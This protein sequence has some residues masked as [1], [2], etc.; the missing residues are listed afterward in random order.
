MSERSAGWLSD[1]ELENVAP[2]DRAAFR[3]RVPALIVSDGGCNLAPQTEAQGRVEG[4]I[5]EYNEKYA[6]YQGVDRRTFLKSA[7][8]FAAAFLGINKVFGPVFGVSEAEAAEDKVLVSTEW[9]ADNL[10]A[11]DQRILDCSWYLPAL[12]R[13]ARADYRAKHLPGAVFFDIDEIADRT[14]LGAHM[15]PSAE[16]F[17]EKVGKLGIDNQTRVVVYDTNYVSARVWW[18][19]RVFGHDN[20]VVLNGKLTKWLAEGRPVESGEVSVAPRTFVA[21]KRPELVADWREVLDNITS[22]NAQ[23][24]D[25]RTATRYLGKLPTG[26]PGIRAGYVPG[27]VNVPWDTIEDP[28]TRQFL[29]IEALRER[30]ASSGVDIDKPIIAMCGSGVVAPILAMS[31][32]RLGR[33]D[34]KLYDG[35]WYEWAQLP[36]V[37]K[38]WTEDE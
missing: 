25:A 29:P 16:V 11:P 3:S 19:F 4:L 32:H 12:K 36:Q 27:S 35:S 10:Q 34:W 18:M 23:L 33:S 31:L 13:D 8:G 26:Y 5:Q 15:L 14:G 28:Q 37:P 21:R 1:R 17:A 7:S 20:V 6:K 2:A 30:F 38:V 22:R 24:V 9:L